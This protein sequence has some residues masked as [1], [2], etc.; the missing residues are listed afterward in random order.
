MKSILLPY[1]QFFL[2]NEK[3]KDNLA[4]NPLKEYYL[5]SQK[6]APHWLQ[7]DR[8]LTLGTSQNCLC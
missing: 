2:S 4:S 5:L 1:L 6:A 7:S 8:V 3:I